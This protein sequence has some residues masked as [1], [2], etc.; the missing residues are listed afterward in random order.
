MTKPVA[1]SC[2]YKSHRTTA[3]GGFSVTFDAPEDAADQINEIFKKK[4]ERLYV[5]V[6]TEEESKSASK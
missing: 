3:D 6:M 1:I 2:V 5:V 4:N